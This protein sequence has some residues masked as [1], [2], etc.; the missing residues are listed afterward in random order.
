MLRAI[1][2]SAL[3]MLSLAS[4]EAAA[5]PAAKPLV[6]RSI[7]GFILPAYARFHAS[8][9]RL[10][11]A[12]DDLCAAPSADALDAAR[13]A[14]RDTV[15]AWSTAEIIR[16]GPVTEENRQERILFWPDRKG[17]GLK[18]VQAAMAQGDTTASDADTLAGKSVAMQGLGALEFV[19]H[20]T[21]ADDLAMAPGSYR[22]AYGAAVAENLDRMAGEIE[23]GW[24]APDG[25][26]AA[27]ANPGPNNALYRD[28]TEALGE[29]LDVFVN[30]LELVR[31]VRL[32]GFLGQQAADDK[33]RQALFWRSAQTVPALGANISALQALFDA[34]GLAAEL[35]T[36]S[37]W[38]GESIGFEF[39]NA[40]GAAKAA[41]GPVAEVLQTPAARGKLDYLR[42]VT[43]SLSDLFG[44]RLSAEFGVT[45]G[46]SSLDGD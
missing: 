11:D 17:T 3:V 31:D 13:N 18:Q 22:C 42:V 15:Q 12:V 23:Q 4:G 44:T 24:Q 41:D 33:P 6:E 43:S 28:D 8:T 19:L 27:W 40:I 10:G 36:T 21:G 39:A 16:F 1:V 34:S 14:F 25:I 2:A 20:G 32:N 37:N 9:A 7:A 46:F 29:L 26:A 45:A 5:T 35:P 38:I 30:G